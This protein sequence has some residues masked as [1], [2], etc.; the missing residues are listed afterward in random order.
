MKCNKNISINDIINNNDNILFCKSCDNCCHVKYLSF[1]MNTESYK[2]KCEKCFKC[3]MCKSNKYYS[4]N[5]PLNKNKDYSFFTRDYDYCYECGLTVFY[6]SLCNKCLLSDFKNIS[7]KL[8]FIKTRNDLENFENEYNINQENIININFN[9]KN[10]KDEIKEKFIIMLYC[11]S[12]KSWCHS[13]CFGVNYLEIKE[14]FNKFN[15]ID[16]FICLDCFLKNKLGE[17]YNKL[18]AIT[19]LEILSTS[20]KLMVLSK[21]ILIILKGHYNEVNSSIKLHSKLIKTFI[22]NNYETMLKNKNIQILFNLF[23]IDTFLNKEANQNNSS[24]K[25]KSKNISNI[26]N[27]KIINNNKTNEYN[28]VNIINSDGNISEQINIEYDEDIENQLDQLNN[29]Q[30]LKKVHENKYWQQHLMRL[31]LKKYKKKSSYQRTFKKK[32]L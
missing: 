20:F 22:K 8:I 11:E 14:Y 15:D 18:S 16:Y 5:F 30:N 3:I 31:L 17:K 24:K 12:C 32:L 6:N 27:N 25:K 19:Y 7:K 21:V 23:K 28:L 9:D 13:S 2:Y 1:V 10:E 26:D 4:E 29:Q